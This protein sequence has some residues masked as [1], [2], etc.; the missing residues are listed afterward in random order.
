MI[1]THKLSNCILDFTPYINK[2]SAD[3]IFVYKKV[4]D[5]S[6]RIAMYY[7]P[8][9]DK[10]K[11]YPIFVFIHGGGWSR[12]EVFPDQTEWA[13]DH[14]G[15][16]ARYYAE[17]GFISASIDYRLMKSNGQVLDYELPDLIVDCVDALH[18]LKERENEMGI[19]FSR[20]VLLG[21]SAGGYLASAL[22]TLKFNCDISIKKSILVNAISDMTE[23]YWGKYYPLNVADKLL[24]SPVHQ[25]NDFTPPVLLIHG[26]KDTVVSPKH[27]QAFYEQ[28]KRHNRQVELHWIEDTNHAFLLAEFMLQ[29]KQPLS[30]TE[31]G[32]Q[33]INKFIEVEEK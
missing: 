16:L 13:G 11:K 31:I 25:I 27:S 24:F 8:Q 3:E 29:N 19:D 30:A 20:S 26:T 23:P 6:L 33:I 18:F 21:E 12:H 7:P 17:K 22:T 14:L 2:H 15:F 9:Y 5:E 28:M 10:N 1:V 4:K 32:V